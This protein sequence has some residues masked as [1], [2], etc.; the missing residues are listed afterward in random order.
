MTG[1]ELISQ[2]RQEHFSKHNRSVEGDKQQNFEYQLADAA[3]ALIAPTPEGMEET[4]V[5]INKD[6]PPIGWDQETWEN[7]LK[8]SYKDRLVVAGSLIAAEIDRIS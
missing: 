3:G 7:L 2:E 6:Y 1:I 5:S 8:K 4:Y